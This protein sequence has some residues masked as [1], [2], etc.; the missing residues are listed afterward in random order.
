MP[1]SKE[2]KRA[3]AGERQARWDA[4]PMFDKLAA[5]HE[6]PGESKRERARM[7]AAF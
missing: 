5:L 3:E 4:T 1:K 7:L 2:Q 6:R